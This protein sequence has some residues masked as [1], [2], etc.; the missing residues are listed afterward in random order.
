MRET[1]AREKEREKHTKDLLQ[2]VL[3]CLELGEAMI[4]VF[5]IYDSAKVI[6]TLPFLYVE[7]CR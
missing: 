3:V 7:K 4:K 2:F 1:L 5:L 6:P